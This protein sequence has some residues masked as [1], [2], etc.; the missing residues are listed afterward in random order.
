MGAGVLVVQGPG[1]QAFPVPQMPI[2]V[3]FSDGTVAGGFVVG[4][5]Q[6]KTLIDRKRRREQRKKHEREIRVSEN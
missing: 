5:K 3:A 1:K 6:A 4:A 2:W